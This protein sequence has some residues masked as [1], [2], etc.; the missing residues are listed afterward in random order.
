MTILNF[1]ILAMNKLVVHS[2]N[3]FL[4]VCY[5]SFL[6]TVLFSQPRGL[7]QA[8]YFSVDE[9]KAG[10]VS[11]TSAVLE[12]IAA[13]AMLRLKKAGFYLFALTEFIGVLF[14]LNDF[15]KNIIS[16]TAFFSGLFFTVV[17]IILF[18]VNLKHMDD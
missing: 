17:W 3:S 11:I 7:I 9:Y 14:R 1:K 15:E 8:K 12:I 6:S 4:M 18:A 5:F 10:A 13:T 2:K 16:D